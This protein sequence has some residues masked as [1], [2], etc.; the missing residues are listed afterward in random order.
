MA[1][2]AVNWAT[3]IPRAERGEAM[4]RISRGAFVAALLVVL[5]GGASL[6]ADTLVMRDGSG[7]EIFDLA[8][9]TAFEEAGAFPN[10]PPAIKDDD[11]L[12]RFNFSFALVLGSASRPGF[13][14]SIS[15]AVRNW[16]NE[17]RRGLMPPPR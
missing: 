15:P 10:P 7:V 11:G 16:Q 3:G 6:L 8:G 1:A 12:I 17:Y 2:T 4:K 5:V 13:Q 14:L 9:M